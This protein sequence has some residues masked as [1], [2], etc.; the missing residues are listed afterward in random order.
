MHMHNF[1]H[2]ISPN[3]FNIKVAESGLI[4]SDRKL[5]G[6]GGTNQ[7]KA[8]ENLEMYNKMR[9][10]TRNILYYYLWSKILENK[11]IHTGRRHWKSN[12]TKRVL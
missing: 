12:N 3:E 9:F 10:G 7:E 5:R 11:G 8:F 4:F 6:V 2:V 1:K